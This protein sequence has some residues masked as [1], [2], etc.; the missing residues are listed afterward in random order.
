MP[1]SFP[2]MPFSGARVSRSTDQTGIAS[3]T[4]TAITFDAA[5]YDYASYWNSATKLTA[6]SAGVYRV[7]ANARWKAT[8]SS[9]SNRSLYLRLNGSTYIAQWLSFPSASVNIAGTLA[10]DYLLAAGDYLEL[11]VYQDSGGT[12]TVDCTTIA[13]AYMCI[14]KLA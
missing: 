5:Q 7:F 10:I 4:F 9:G 13:P 12:M 14:S 6:P 1:I 3:A 2:L 11:M 8:S